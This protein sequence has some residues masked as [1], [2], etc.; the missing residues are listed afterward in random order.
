[1]TI[2][3][4]SER[5]GAKGDS[6]GQLYEKIRNK[7]EFASSPEL[8]SFLANPTASGAR[9]ARYTHRALAESTG[10]KAHHAIA[11]WCKELEEHL[12]GEQEVPEESSESV[13]LPTAPRKPQS[14][15]TDPHDGEIANSLKKG[16]YGR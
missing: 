13:G 12:S 4:R 10:N 16:P 2:P 14:E 8:E 3:P 6:P 1:M 15:W 5:F 9:N 11:G 7:Q